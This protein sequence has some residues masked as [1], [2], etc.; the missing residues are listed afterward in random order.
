MNYAAYSGV[1]AVSADSSGWLELN[2]ISTLTQTRFR[3]LYGIKF[4]QK[5]TP[6]PAVSEKPVYP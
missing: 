6:A 2:A 5:V 3:T 1:Y 4:N